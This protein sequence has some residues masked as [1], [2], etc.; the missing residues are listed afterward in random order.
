MSAG[1]GG[2]YRSRLEEMDE[3]ALSYL[4]SLAE[5]QEILLEDIEGTEAHVIMLCEQGIIPRDDAAKILLAL[6]ELREKVLQGELRLEGGYEDVHELIESKVIEK[7]GIEVGGKLHTGRSRND[8]VA[9]DIRLRIRRLLLELW[10]AALKLA[11]ELLSRA[12]KELETPM[13]HYTHLQHAQIGYVSQYLLAH[14]D[15]LLRDI[16]RMES[17]YRR[18]NK[19]PLGACAVAGSTLPLNRELVARLLGF[20]GVVENSVDAVSSRDFALEAL[21][22]AAIMMTNLSRIAEDIIIWSTSEFGYLE[23]PDSLASPSSIMPHKKNP[24]I[25]EL[26]RAKTAKVIG[27]LAGSLALMKGIPTGY[28]RDLQEGKPMIWEALKE[29]RSSLMMMAKTIRLVRFNADRLREAV[30]QSYAPAIELTEA[31]MKH[32]GLSLR[33]AHKLVGYMVK[34]LHEQ[35]R[36]LKT[37]KPEEL[38]AAAS[39]VLGKSII[40][41]PEILERAIEPAEIMRQ[42]MTLGSASPQEIRRMLEKRREALNQAWARLRE[43]ENNLLLARQFFEESLEKIAKK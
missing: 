36:A 35:G 41:P 30:E 32:A 15:H 28:D 31:L 18:T 14:L 3:E 20:D 16:E 6:E 8:Q 7:L 40:V 26:L 11:E 25:L 4:S 29:T 37:L 1:R 22:A 42:R 5:D 19:S 38:S 43:V 33:E 21:S 27:L 34:L 39:R 23:L 24:C 2:L 17:C 10:R 12:E 9:L 13:I